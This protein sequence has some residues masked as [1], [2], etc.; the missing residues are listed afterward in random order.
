MSQAGS[1]SSSGGGGGGSGITWNVVSGTSQAIVKSNGY[2]NTNVGLTTF[3][4]PA[5][6]AVGDSFRIAGNGSGLWTIAQNA[7]QLI[8]FGNTTTST[9]VAGSLAA[10]LTH[11]SVEIVC[12]TA[13]TTWQVI[14]SIG[15]LTV[16]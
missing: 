10:I 1:V 5:T 11:D 16:T 4:L 13:N 9:G 12:I 6:A 15:N 8:Y 3:T 2:I 14:S 7:G